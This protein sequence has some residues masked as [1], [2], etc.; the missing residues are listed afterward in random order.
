MAC[1]MQ[2][3]G[4]TDRMCNHPAQ[5]GSDIGLRIQRAIQ[6]PA[7]QQLQ[8]V[9]RS[10]TFSLLMSA[11]RDK[12]A[13]E[14][15]QVS[16]IVPVR[17]ATTMLHVRTSDRP[18]GHQQ[19]VLF[20]T[21]SHN[22]GRRSIEAKRC[23]GGSF[24]KRLNGRFVAVDVETN[25]KM[26]WHGGKIFCWSYFTDKGE[27]GFMLNTPE[28]LE[29]IRQLFA[30]PDKEVIFHNAKFDLLM[31]LFEGIDI[32][33]MQA[34]AHCTLILSKLLNENGQHDLRWL[35]MHYNNRNT[36]DKDE[37]KDWLKAHRKDFMQRH[38]R[39]PNF[40]DAPLDIVKRRCMW[41]TE[42]TLYLFWSLKKRLGTEIS[43]ELYE[44]ER[45]LQFV[46]IDMESIGV[47][48]DLTRARALR[49]KAKQD[50]DRILEDLRDLIGDITIYRAKC[51]C[52]ESRKG[53]LIRQQV[54]SADDEVY[55]PKC[56]AQAV[57]ESEVVTARGDPEGSNKKKRQG[58]NP[59][60]SQLH[61][62]AAFKK[63]G[64]ELKYKTLPKKGKKGGEKKGG[65]QWSFDEY[66]MIR[67]VSKPIASIIRDSGE[68]GWTT[69][70]FYYA[71]KQ[72]VEKH[73]LD[74]QDLVPPLILKYRELDKMIST[75]Y[76]H[77]IEFAVDRIVEPN[78]RETGVVHGKFNQSEAMTGRFSSSEP[79]L[80]NMPRL[81]GPRECF[82]TRKSRWNWHFDYEQAEMRF[83]AHFSEDEDIIKA[84]E[85]DIH[86]TMASKIYN[87]PIEKVTSEQRKRVKAIN[88]GILYGAG[89]AKMADTLTR[90]GI[91]TSKAEAERIVAEYHRRFPSIRRLTNRLKTELIRHGFV[92]NPFGRRYH[93]PTRFAYKALN[94][95]CQ[96]ASADLM[97]QGMVKVWKWLRK[98]KLTSRILLTVHDELCVEIPPSERWIVPR[99]KTLMED[100][101]SFKVPIGVDVEVA[102]RR[103]SHKE[104]YKWN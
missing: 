48:V 67:Y 4:Q 17:H 9:S 99:I 44:Q 86:L 3:T 8:L 104:E 37:I 5:Y 54:L 49:K 98:H 65:G 45:Q 39:P 97:K 22:R 66:A 102:K 85:G 43:E 83:F 24:H 47:R 1:D 62:P 58:F 53:K 87:I 63:I 89:A 94:Y 73:G 26:P 2:T 76:D 77:F 18:S 71:I 57:I 36:D 21:V 69:D 38:G 34:K 46:V 100:A 64:I 12:R 56:G 91:P 82:I 20:P 60:S 15:G 81:L 31:F 59:N 52:N 93:I 6:E 68:E 79:N 41:D 30:D 96:G 50:R 75:Y 29:W 80:Q 101:H 14:I 72:A 74:E 92:E 70:A 88:F 33:E 40:T 84:I 90:R 95:L 7:Q 103:W 10:A 13:S 35:S 28:T 55:C 25:G 19:G 78:G 61:L 27:Y 42:S 32:Y 23:R 51:Y 16:G 11:C